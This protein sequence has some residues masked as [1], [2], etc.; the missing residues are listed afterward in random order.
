MQLS[1]SFAS[2]RR[3]SDDGLRVKFSTAKVDV[4]PKFRFEYCNRAAVLLAALE[5]ES[6]RNIEF[7]NRGLGSISI[8]FIAAAIDQ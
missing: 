1:F 2:T 3:Q 7:V 4:S 5:R 8:F 6:D